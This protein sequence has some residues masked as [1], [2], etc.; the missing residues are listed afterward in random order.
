MEIHVNP[1][2]VILAGEN[3]F[4]GLSLDGGTTRTHWASHWRVFWSEAGAGHVLFVDS[5]LVEGLRILTDNADLARFVQENVEY[6]LHEP[7]SDTRLPVGLAAFARAGSPPCPV[8]ET[9]DGSG[10]SVQ[11]TWS[12]FSDPFSF[13]TTPGFK[14][15]ALGHHTTFF[16]ARSARLSV[17]GKPAAGSPWSD[18]RGEEEC[19]STCLAW[20]ETWYRP[21]GAR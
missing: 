8:S 18:Q 12:G 5:E 15:R 21:T 6:F 2:R 4:I 14:G 7:F 9:V 17:N 16:P 3:S 11:L 20:C 1:H 10:Y 19:T 13:A